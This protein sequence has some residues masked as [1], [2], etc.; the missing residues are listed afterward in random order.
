MYGEK[1]VNLEPKEPCHKNDLDSIK[2]V[3]EKLEEI[4]KLMNQND[5]TKIETLAHYILE[6]CSEYTDIKKIYLESLLANNKPNEVLS[7]IREKLTE[8]EKKMEEFEY[9]QAKSWYFLA[10]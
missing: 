2:Y 3:N 8:D 5:Y 4:K 1:C 6:K 10:N 7:F 9:F